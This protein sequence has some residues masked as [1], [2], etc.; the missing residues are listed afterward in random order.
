[1]YVT[2][3]VDGKAA[4]YALAR[5]GKRAG[6][7]RPIA[8]KLDQQFVG[9][10]KRLFDSQGA[11]GASGMWNELRPETIRRKIVKNQDTR[12]LQAKHDLVDSLTRRS[13]PNHILDA[14]KDQIRLG[15]KDPKA[16]FHHRAR[17]PERQRKVIDLTERQRRAWMRTI[18]RYVLDGDA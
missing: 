6:D 4:T 2:I 8:K 11:T 16:Q 9:F 1:M 10:E 7:F 15:T 18:Q 13:D 12:I 3:E 14:S 17:K 5:I